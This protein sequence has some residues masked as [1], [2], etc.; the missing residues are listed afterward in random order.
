[1]LCR[2][3]FDMGVDLWKGQYVFVRFCNGVSVC[4]CI[5]SPIGT[6]IA[7]CICMCMYVYACVYMCICMCMVYMRYPQAEGI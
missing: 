3:W 1:M 4:L 5:L 6:S 2:S 7:Q